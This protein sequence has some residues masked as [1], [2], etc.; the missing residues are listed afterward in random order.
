MMKFL[1]ASFF[2]LVMIGSPGCSNDNKAQ[3]AMNTLYQND[4]APAGDS[5]RRPFP[6][7]TGALNSKFPPGSEPKKLM[8]YVASLSGSCGRVNSNSSLACTFVESSSFCIRT[9]VSVV[10]KIVG[11]EKIGAIETWHVLEGC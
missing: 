1:G 5:M 11:A 9:N 2:L 8:D 4:D 10:A 3:I 7:L 6:A